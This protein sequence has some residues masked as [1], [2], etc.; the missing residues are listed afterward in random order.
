MLLDPQLSPSHPGLPCA[1][2]PSVIANGNIGTNDP[3]TIFEIHGTQCHVDDIT[4]NEVGT[5]TISR[6]LQQAGEENHMRTFHAIDL[7]HTYCQLYSVRVLAKG[8][9]VSTGT[10]YR[11]ADLKDSSISA[12]GVLTI[13]LI[14]TI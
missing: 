12:L 11:I 10:Q 6:S 14:I 1:L 5:I 8:G 13:C 3:Y 7:R 2:H 4:G 9:D